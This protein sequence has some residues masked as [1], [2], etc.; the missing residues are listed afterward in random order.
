MT[1]KTTKQNAREVMHNLYALLDQDDA[2][3]ASFCDMFTTHT[4]SSAGFRKSLDA[5]LDEQLSNDAFG[6]DGQNDPRGDHR[7]DEEDES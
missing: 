5:W 1:Y 2:L 6:T 7:D 4:E 3:W